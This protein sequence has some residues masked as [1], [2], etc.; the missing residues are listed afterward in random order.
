MLDILA[1]Y[2]EFVIKINIYNIK[3]GGIILGKILSVAK[4]KRWRW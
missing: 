2:I 4:S 3:Q 1:T